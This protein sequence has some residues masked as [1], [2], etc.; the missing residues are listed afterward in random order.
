[1]DQVEMFSGN[2]HKAVKK[3]ANDWLREQKDKVRT[4]ERFVSTA[5]NGGSCIEYTITIFWTTKPIGA[6]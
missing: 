1:M 4:V 6:Q 2:D 5:G 3:A